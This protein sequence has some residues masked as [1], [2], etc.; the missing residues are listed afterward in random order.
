MHVYECSAISS[1]DNNSAKRL[2]QKCQ[3][4]TPVLII[5]QNQN[6]RITHHIPNIFVGPK[7]PVLGIR[8]YIC[9]RTQGRAC[10]IRW[11]SGSWWP[12]LATDTIKPCWHT[13]PCHETLLTV[14][15]WFSSNAIHAK[16][17]KQRTQRK[18]RQRY[19][20][21]AVINRVSKTSHF[22][23]SNGAVKHRSILTVF[24]KQHQEKTWRKWRY[25][26]PTSPWCC[27]YTTFW[28]AEVVVWPFTIMH[29]YWVAHVS[30]QKIIVRQQNHWN[31]V[32]YLVLSHQGSCCQTC[33]KCVADHCL[34]LHSLI[35]VNVWKQV[36]KSSARL[37]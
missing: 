21:T 15:E 16:Y 2:A 8:I 13:W 32:T 6:Y 12:W 14:Y 20:Y 23:F 18:N 26:L 22:Y 34:K 1:F 36:V 4:N 17:A 25:I 3:K 35:F 28:S 5:F 9:V 7:N 31:A 30:A 27:R 10:E 11:Q 37:I 33:V 29:S 24:G 19:F